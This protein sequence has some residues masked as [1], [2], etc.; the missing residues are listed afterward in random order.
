MLLYHKGSNF[1]YLVKPFDIV[2]APN[3]VLPIYNGSYVERKEEKLTE[4]DGYNDF[5]VIS[6]SGHS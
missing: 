6:T 5:R 2:D 3:L 1:T 4:I